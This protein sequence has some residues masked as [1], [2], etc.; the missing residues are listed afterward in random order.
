MADH[1]FGRKAETLKIAQQRRN[2]LRLLLQIPSLPTEEPK[3]HREKER[4]RKRNFLSYQ[5]FCCYQFRGSGKLLLGKLKLGF[6]EINVLLTV[7]R[8]QM[9]VCVRNFQS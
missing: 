4:V 9:D 1:R 8:H 3:G 7:K 5:D 2:M 6:G